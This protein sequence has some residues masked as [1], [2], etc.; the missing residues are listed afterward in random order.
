MEQGS[1]Q[2]PELNLPQVKLN[3]IP[4][5]ER[6]KVLDVIRQRYVVLTPEEWVR[7]HVV[8]YL[9]SYLEVPQTLIGVEQALKVGRMEKRSDIAVYSR[10]GKPLLLVECKA[11]SVK[12]SQEVID[13]ALRYN[14]SLH[15]QFVMITNG[16]SHMGYAIDYEKQST[17]ALQKL[18][19]YKEMVAGNIV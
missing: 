11:P 18:P 5:N 2:F 8:H 15:V 10:E 14:M 13:Q 6:V 4:E 12:L 16:L 7:Q 3:M 17:T 19:S 9:I 1:Q